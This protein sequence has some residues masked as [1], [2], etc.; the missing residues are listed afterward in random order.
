[1]SVLETTKILVNGY[2]SNPGARFGCF[3]IRNMYLNTKLPSPEYKKIQVSLIT[4]EVTEE[5]NFTQ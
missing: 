3:E 2:I 5:Y 1:M 4:Q